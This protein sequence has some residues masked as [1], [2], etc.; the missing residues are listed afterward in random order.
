MRDPDILRDV[1]AGFKQLYQHYR[2]AGGPEM[3]RANAA[4]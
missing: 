3:P 4:A 1:H 2:D